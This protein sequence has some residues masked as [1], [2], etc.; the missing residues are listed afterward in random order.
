MISLT[1]LTGAA[2]IALA[3]FI[4]PDQAKSIPWRDTRVL[5]A[6]APPRVRRPRFVN[7]ANRAG[8]YQL[9]LVADSG[10]RRGVRTAGKLT[11][12]SLPDTITNA[13]SPR[14]PLRGKTDIR[15]E[16]VGAAASGDPAADSVPWFGV[17]VMQ[18][19]LRDR[20]E[21]LEGQG[22]R[23]LFLGMLPQTDVTA[24]VLDVYELR[25]SGFSGY[26][27]TFG[28]GRFHPAAGHFCA[29]SLPPRTRPNV[30]SLL[31]SAAS[32]WIGR[33]DSNCHC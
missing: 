10:P 30:A 22:G 14:Y 24:T 5:A 25:P 7:L 18:A 3:A 26:W 17:L 33:L 29:D 20:D 13:E 23:S 28:S 19:P 15:L 1:K 32:H 31:S 11:L 16:Q 27:R 2:I 21:P 12:L 6:C 4:G 8:D 9:V